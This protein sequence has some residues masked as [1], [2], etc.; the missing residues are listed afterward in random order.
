MNTTDKKEKYKADVLST[1]FLDYFNSSEREISFE[2]TN[3]TLKQQ[4]Q[5]LQE[6]LENG[7][8]NT[9]S[10]AERAE[11]E[12]ALKETSQQISEFTARSAEFKKEVKK[13]EEIITGRENCKGNERF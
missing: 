7:V 12:M 1:Q 2:V 9:Q 8:T 13:T 11:I 4:L 5:E 6:K 3:A 10:G